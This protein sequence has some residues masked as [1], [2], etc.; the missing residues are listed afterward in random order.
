MNEIYKISCVNRL[1]IMIIYFISLT[2]SYFL[3][4]VVMTFNIG[5]FFAAVAG[6]TFGYFLFGFNNKK[7]YTRV[8][9]PETDKCCTAME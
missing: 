4:L 3:M 9:Y 2:L 5:L 1:I 7:G 8:Y 6:F